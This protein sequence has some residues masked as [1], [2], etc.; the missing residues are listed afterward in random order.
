MDQ[1]SLLQLLGQ[2]QNLDPPNEQPAAG[3]A[4]YEVKQDR[5]PASEAVIEA[6]ND[7]KPVGERMEEPEDEEGA[8]EE[9]TATDAPEPE[10]TDLD[11]ESATNSELERLLASLVPLDPSAYSNSAYPD[12][13]EYPTASSSASYAELTSYP[14]EPVPPAV[15]TPPIYEEPP[16]IR[17]FTFAQALPVVSRLAEDPSFIDQLQQVRHA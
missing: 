13:P 4:P 12:Y 5:E 11:N 8:L 15:P 16:D 2:L 17:K 9:A 6:A 10:A 7:D 1:T 14:S 3:S